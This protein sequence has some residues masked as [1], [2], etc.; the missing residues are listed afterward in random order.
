M[1]NVNKCGLGFFAV[2][3]S[4]SF[5]AASQ[6]ATITY[7]GGTAPSTNVL[8]SQTT[9]TTGGL[10]GNNDFTDNGGPP[11]ELFTVATESKL[12]TISVLGG[13]NWG[14]PSG[15]HLLIGSV[16]PTTQAV[17][18]LNGTLGIGGGEAAPIPTNNN[19]WVSFMLATPIVLN[20]GTEYVWSLYTDS[21]WY[22][23]AHSVAGGTPGAVNLNTTDT[24]ENNNS[25]G[26][27]NGG[28][29]GFAALNTGDY[30]Y[31][32][33][34]QGVVVPE[35]SSLVVLCSLGGIGLFMLARRRKV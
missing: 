30:Q 25:G 3:T 27:K 16:N 34:A 9:G 13:G 19:D 8:A 4:L 1:L 24:F 15:M 18:P 31:A 14:P 21:N 33:V 11:G 2:V 32:F 35:P 12:Q 17:T 26:A 22:G 20:P 10:N 5:A 7:E 23:L 29:N 6:A 28:F